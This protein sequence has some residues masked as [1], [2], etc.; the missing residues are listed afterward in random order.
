MSVYDFDALTNDNVAKYGEEGKD[1]GKGRFTIDD[2]KG[3]IVDFEAV[4]EV[5]HTGPTGIGVSDDNHLVAAVDEFLE[6][7]RI[8]ETSKWCS[9]TYTRQLVHVTLHSSY[10]PYETCAN[11]RRGYAIPG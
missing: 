7:V 8:L 4:G 10:S 6:H 5:S 2:E 1:G 3:D 11:I 9:R